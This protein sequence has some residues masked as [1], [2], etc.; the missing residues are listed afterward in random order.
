MMM[1][2]STQQQELTEIFADKSIAKKS[3]VQQ[4]EWPT[5]M[6]V[7]TSTK[8]IQVMGWKILRSRAYVNW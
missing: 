2:I 7:T 6:A 4:K 5:T 1:R 8:E 3:S